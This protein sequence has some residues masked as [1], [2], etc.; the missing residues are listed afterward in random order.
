MSLSAYD[1]TAATFTTRPVIQGRFGVV[2]SG[3]Y[4]ASEI[5]LRILNAG[6]NAVD[7]GVAGVLA[8]TVLKPQ[9]CGIAGESPMLLWRPPAESARDKLP[10]PLSINGQGTAPRAAT[11]EWFRSQGIDMIPGDGLLAT[12]VPATFDACIE[13]LRVG[14]RLGIVEVLEPAVELAREGFAV[15]PSLREGIARDQHLYRERYPST[16]SVC[17]DDGAV[18]HV[19][20][21][22]RQP[23]WAATFQGVLDAAVR[24]RPGG[25]EAELKAAR[26]HFYRG[27]I[28]ARLV[29]FA[30]ATPVL[31]AT[32]RENRGLIDEDDFAN[33]RTRLEE[34]VTVPYRG[35]DV[36]KCDSWTQGP[37]F[38][39]QLRLLEGFDLPA[40]GHNSPDYVHVL[41]EAA[42]LAYADRER[43]YGDPEFAEVPMRRLLSAE[44][45][46]ERR[47]LI[48]MGEASAE[49]RP[50]DVEPGPVPMVAG[51]RVGT[52]RDTTHIDVID[53]EGRMFAATPSGGWLPSSPI[54]PGLG[55]PLGSRLQVF[56]LD[57]SHPNALRPGK[58]PRT[59][60][61]PSLATRD[62]RPEM[63][64]G[65]PGGD[66][67]DQ[68][69][70]Q[71]FLNIVDF[72]MDLQAA[73]DAP[74]FHSQ[75][76]P[77]SFYPH[78][79]FPKRLVVEG[80]LPDATVADLRAR[81]H[82]VVVGGDWEHGQVNVV[83]F[84]PD[85]GRI[86]GAASPRS[87]VAY[88]MGR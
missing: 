16:G 6:G 68:H 32:G 4:L 54:V 15:Y 84:H 37:V 24:A 21:W 8:L 12:T 25:R 74:L 58:R 19:G 5:S 52:G 11:I 88:A 39:Q 80:R 42:K 66:N 20:W 41:T 35:L 33:Y 85:E 26:D 51:D 30:R 78:E 18:P 62:G 65:T 71:A 81:G 70:L 29:D 10:N 47:R 17:L 9:S 31:D 14:G 46:A 77:S 23:E 82:E 63:V 49:M 28:A 86:E 87:M 83:R 44:Y 56:N 67:Q 73:L 2:S 76:F 13:A 43:Y 27:P 45:A 53:G 75:H 3:H 22:Y 1:I 7:A 38:L 50:G 48:D 40:L 64:F 55:F 34:P 61:T 69:T 57:P 60:L 36:Y 79:A 72:G 59:T